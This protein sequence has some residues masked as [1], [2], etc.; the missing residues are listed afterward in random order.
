[1]YFS[2]V[3]GGS[4]GIGR[5]ICVKLAE[6]GHN[7][8]I[9]YTSNEAKALETKELV[10]DKGVS[11]EIIKFDVSDRDEVKKQL[12]NWQNQHKNDIINVLI[13][14]AGIRKDNLMLW[15][16]DEDWDNVLDIS[17]GGFY[18]V[19]KQVLTGMV[20]N[21]EGRIVNVVSISGVKGMAGQTNYSAAKAGIIGA[22]KSLAQEIGK[23]NITV[24]AI[25][26]GFI[27]TDMTE[28]LDEKQYRSL[29]PLNR[30][31]NPE[32]VAEVA[33]FLASKG[34]SYVT[35]EVITVSGGL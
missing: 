33:G 29:I 13:N 14:N 24:N 2:L 10:E 17:L 30:F 28:D 20:K 25:A 27:K 1:M 22:T 18:N 11:A 8:L 35:G 26:P 15:M 32:E 19:T 5:A 3:T 12:E 21:R 9:N 16:K 31:G 4:R 23:R 6:K 34:A 7:I